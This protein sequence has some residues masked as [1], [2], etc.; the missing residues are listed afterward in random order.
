MIPNCKGCIEEIKTAQEFQEKGCNVILENMGVR[1]HC[2][3]IAI[4]SK[5]CKFVAG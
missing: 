4:D 2:F 5:T 3:F 1:E